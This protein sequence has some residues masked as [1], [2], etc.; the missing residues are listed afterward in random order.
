MNGSRRVGARPMS[1]AGDRRRA[2]PRS[3]SGRGTSPRPRRRAR[4]AT[5]AAAAPRHRPGRRRRTATSS[6]G[7]AAA[8]RRDASIDDVDLVGRRER[9]GVDE[10]ERAVLART[11]GARSGPGRTGRATGCS[12]RRRPCRPARP[13]RI[14]RSRI[15][16][17]TVTAASGE[18]DRQPLLEQQQAVGDRVRR[19]AGSAIRKNSGI[20]SW[21]SRRTGTPTSRSGRAANA[22]KSGSE[23]TWTSAKRR[24]RC[25]RVSGPRRPDE[26]REV[27]AQ[28]RPEA[29]ALVAL[30]VEA[31]DGRRRRGRRAARRRGAAGRRR[32]PGGPPR[33]ATRPRGGRAGPRRS[34]LWT[35]MSDRP[36]RPAAACRRR[37]QPPL[38]P[39]PSR[40]TWRGRTS[41]PPRAVDGVDDEVGAR[42]DVRP[43]RSA[44][45]AVT[46]TTTSARPR[47]VVE[48]LRLVRASRSR[49]GTSARAGRGSGRPRRG[50]SSPA[51]TSAAGELR[52]SRTFGLKA[53]PRTPT[54]APLS[55]RPRS[56][57]A[58]ATR[59]TTWRGIA[60]LMSP[61]SSTKRSTKS[62]SRARQ[63]R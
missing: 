44:V 37:A 31:V 5:A 62:N 53:T 47:S 39:A 15:A 51:M 8:Q 6:S 26:E 49:R 29:G 4:A 50:R 14:S 48:R 58:S 22:R 34:R 16:S 21:R 13:S 56:L 24:R 25:A 7:R 40:S 10:P 42:V 2:R 17:L 11:A 3:G 60:K 30:D 27:L 41:R 61:A 32:R 28:V 23:W 46:T 45:W 19:P 59:S 18:R 9:A 20:A 38:Q 57:S 52:A 63:A 36:A 33:R 1:A 35:I 12:R 43:S 54:R 55:A